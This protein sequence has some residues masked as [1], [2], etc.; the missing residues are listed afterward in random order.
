[1]YFFKDHITIKKEGGK[2]MLYR[3][4][5]GI[6]SDLGLTQQEMANYL[7]ISI[8]AYRN[9]EKGEAPFNQIEMIL[10][11][12][13]ANMT[14]EEAGALFFNKESNLELYKYFL[15]DLLYK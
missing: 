5:K 3:K 7:G 13:K 10:I 11:M 6:R 1:M 8:R 14:P 4:I 15:T 9:K 12:E 2:G